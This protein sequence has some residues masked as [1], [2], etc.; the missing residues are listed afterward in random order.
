MQMTGD[1]SCSRSFCRRSTHQTSMSCLTGHDD[2][3]LMNTMTYQCVTQD[4]EAHYSIGFE[5]EDRT[6]QQYQ[7]RSRGIWVGRCPVLFVGWGRL[8]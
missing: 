3:R 7:E 4:A 2:T 5:Q 6:L 8:C 1:I